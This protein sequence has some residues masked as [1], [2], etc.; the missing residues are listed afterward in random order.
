MT[1][2]KAIAKRILQLCEQNNITI[3]KLS[4]LAG[5]TQSTLNDIVHGKSKNPTIRTIYYVCF[6]LGIELKIF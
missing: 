4:N 1:I 5:I 3:N 6:G 2:N